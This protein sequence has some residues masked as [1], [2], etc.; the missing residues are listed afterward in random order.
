MSDSN[1]RY[2]LDLEVQ[3]FAKRLLLTA[4]LEPGY[5]KSY[6]QSFN[7]FQ[8]NIGFN[9]GLSAAQPDMVEGLDEPEFDPF[10]VRE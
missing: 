2:N 10:P 7:G 9:N 3:S 5:Y 6:N 8:K 4:T 1:P